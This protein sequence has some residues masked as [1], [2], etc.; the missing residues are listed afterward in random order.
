MNTKVKEQLTHFKIGL[1]QEIE[2]RLVDGVE[3]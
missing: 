2:G 1:L 3:A